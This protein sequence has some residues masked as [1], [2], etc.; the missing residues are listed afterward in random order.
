MIYN[1]IDISKLP[2][3]AYVMEERLLKRNLELLKYVADK[4][5]LNILMALKGFALWKSFPLVKNYLVGTSASGLHEALLGYEEFGGEVHTY[6]PAFNLDEIEEIAKISTE[7]IFNSFAQLEK[8][9]DF[10]KEINPNISVGVRLNPEYSSTAVDLYN[11]CSPFSRLGIV[12]SEFEKGIEKYISKIDGFHMHGL[13]EQGV[14]DLEPLFDAF[15][16]NF[17]DY[18]KDLKWINLGG[19]HLITREGYD[20]ER[21]I[22]FVKR[23]YKKYPHIKL[24]I[25]PSEAIGWETGFLVGEVLDIVHNKIDL[26]ILNVSAETHM[27]DVLAMPYR[28]KVVGDV[29]NGQFSYRFGGNSC[30]AGDIIGDFKFEKELKVGNKIVFKD[31]IHYTMVKNTTFNGLPLPSILIVKENGLIEVVKE[32]GYK[33]YK[34]RLS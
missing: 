22:N 33:D 29:E 14:E 19:G 32:F 12:K 28:P 8:H 5:G 10:V 24:Y 21:L 26:A 2:T 1:D 25:E 4:S 23:F 31:M 34:E 18:F 11:P 30:L 9:F 3:P 6:S 13:C 17:G 27:P 7:I 16:K 15:E 20:V